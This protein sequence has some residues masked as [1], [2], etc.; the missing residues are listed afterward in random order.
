MPGQAVE[1]SSS[2]AARQ[3]LP[4]RTSGHHGCWPC[5]EGF[6]RKPWGYA[7]ERLL[8][9][10]T[11]WGLKGEA[12]IDDTD[13]SRPEWVVMDGRRA[14]RIPDIQVACWQRIPGRSVPR[15]PRR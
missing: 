12:W 7:S 4:L 13:P 10:V 2:W 11:S 3:R 6:P 9:V 1:Q 5:D 15:S 8:Q 14:L